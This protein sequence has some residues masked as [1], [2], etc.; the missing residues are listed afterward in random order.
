MGLK[1][2]ASLVTASGKVG[3]TVEIL[4]QGLTGTKSVSFNGTGAKFRRSYPIP[5]SRP[6]FLAGRLLGRCRSPLPKER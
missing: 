4:G 5:T 6:P 1:P 3:K 2:F